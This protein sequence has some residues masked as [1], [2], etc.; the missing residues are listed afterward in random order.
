[1]T[2]PILVTEV[3][4][5]EPLIEP[6]PDL[7]EP[8]YLYKITP[9]LW[10]LLEGKA[11]GK[12]ADAK[13]GPPLRIEIILTTTPGLL[14][15]AWR[16]AIERAAPSFFVENQLGAYVTGIIRPED[17][18]P[19]AASP[20]VSGIRLPFVPRLD[21]DPAVVPKGDNARALRQTRQPRETGDTQFLPPLNSLF[22]Q[23]KLQ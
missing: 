16:G 22:A 9:E 3:M 19:L 2:N 6:P 23:K 7:R 20:F 15:Q 11:D 8:D 14:D 21:R 5:V 10:K 18:R 4:G 13:A 12:D 1:N 17:V